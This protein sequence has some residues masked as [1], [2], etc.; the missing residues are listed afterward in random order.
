MGIENPRGFSE[1]K[2]LYGSEYSGRI[3]IGSWTNA[4]GKAM[5]EA[6]LWVVYDT[7]SSDFWVTSD[8]CKTGPCGRYTGRRYNHSRSA[9]FKAP[10]VK[11][12]IWTTYGSGELR[13]ILGVDDVS[14]GSL[15]VRQQTLG[16]ITSQEGDAF[17]LLPF[18]GIA[19][20][21]FPALAA[22]VKYGS[23]AKNTPLFDNL[24]QQSL[25]ARPEF[26][27]YLHPNLAAGGAVLWGGYDSRLFE[28][29]MHWF[30]VVE[31]R[32]WAL[33]L[34]EFAIGNRSFHTMPK[35]SASW[36]SGARSSADAFR[37]LLIVDSGTTF[38]SATGQVWHAIQ[39]ML[40]P[41]KCSHVHQL[42]PVVY[43]IKDSMGQPQRIVVPPKEY[44]VTSGP[45]NLCMPGFVLV[46]S[47]GQQD[48]S[49]MILGEIFMRHHFTVFSRDHQSSGHAH[50]G[51]ARASH[52]AS[53]QSF[54]QQ[55]QS[56]SGR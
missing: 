53:A 9:T 4:S 21:G 2:D 29:P 8:L 43:T 5:P 51:I 31:E 54:F 38:S 26:A 52:G 24:V 42:P 27:F 44:M 15:T 13:G 3:G 45:D 48:Q 47:F 22:A 50:V 6:E 19:G 14:F 18:D 40:H 23:S 55:A 20:L 30:P 10:Q 28:A 7:G 41:M 56:T 32:Y 37:P 12:E 46:D 17:E 36:W 49:P 39:E 34:V 16:L 35:T 11:Q 33:D 25:L 1:L